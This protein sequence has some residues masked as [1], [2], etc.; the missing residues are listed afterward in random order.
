MTKERDEHFTKWA[1]AV[2]KRLA[3][4]VVQSTHRLAD[5]EAFKQEQHRILARAAYDLVCEGEC[6]EV[7]RYGRV[8]RGEGR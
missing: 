7:D 3:Q 5:L 4:N 8:A 6:R 1:T 2:Y